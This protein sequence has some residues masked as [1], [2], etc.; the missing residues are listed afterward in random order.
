MQRTPHTTLLG[1]IIGQDRVAPSPPV[2]KYGEVEES[3]KGGRVEEK[4]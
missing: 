4:K 3:K 2:Y 1:A